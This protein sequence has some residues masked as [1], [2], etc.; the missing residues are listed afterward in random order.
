[1]QEGFVKVGEIKKVCE[2]KCAVGQNRP[3]YTTYKILYF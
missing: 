3:F 1:M 2:K